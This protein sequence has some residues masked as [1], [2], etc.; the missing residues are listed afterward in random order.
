MSESIG[1]YIAE[2]R[3]TTTV[4]ALNYEV[5]W[6]YKSKDT[7][8]KYVKGMNQYSLFFQTSTHAH[9][10]ALLVELY[11]VALLVDVYLV[12][13]LVELYR[14]YE[15]R[16]DTYNFPGLLKELKSLDAFSEEDLEE[17]EKL[18]KEEAKPLWVKV[19]ILR[20]KAFGHRSNAHTVKEVFEEAGVTPDELRDLVDVT[21]KLMNRITNV[22]DRSTHAF[23]LGSRE[24]LINLLEDLKNLHQC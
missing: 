9:F 22:W 18:Y 7:R 10:V 2:L 21:K 13:L 14:L 16:S 12:A 19:S 1:Q 8:P 15:T 20:N 6:V 11:L 4:A 5:W 23:N 17:I 3:H 24:S